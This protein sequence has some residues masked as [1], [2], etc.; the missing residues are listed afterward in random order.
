MGDW[1]PHVRRAV[2]ETPFVATAVSHDYFAVLGVPL[3]GGGFRATDD[4]P[5]ADA[6][7]IISLPL[8]RALF[9]GVD[10]LGRPIATTR[11]VLTVVGVVQS[12]FR[13]PRVGDHCD[14]WL[15]L[16]ALG[17]FADLARHPGVT[18]L[19]PVTAF[20]RLPSARALGVTQTLVRAV[21]GR[22]G[23]LVPL[24]EAYGHT[25]SPGALVRQRNLLSAMLLV[26]GMI[27]V[28]GAGNLVSLFLCRVED[29]HRSLAIRIALGASRL[30]VIRELL[31]G[32][33]LL[34]GAGLVVALCVASVLTRVIATTELPTGVRVGDALSGLHWFALLAGAAVAS[35]ACMAACLA[36]L[37]RTFAIDIARALA[38]PDR[39]P[40][41]R[42]VASHRAFLAFHSCVATT[43]LVIGLAAT[44]AI[45]S[46]FTDR[47]GFDT[48][49]TAFVAVQPRLAQYS[50]A[51][52]DLDA[53]HRA[54]DYARLLA[55]LRGVADVTSAVVGPTLIESTDSLAP[56]LQ[57]VADGHVHH[58]AAIFRAVGA[59]YLTTLGVPIIQGRDIT[60]MDRGRDVDVNALLRDPAMAARFQVSAQG[61]PPAPLVLAQRP[62]AVIDETLARV[63]WPG[64]SALGQRFSCGF[65]NIEY[66]VIG[67]SAP[68]GLPTDAASPV[69]TVVTLAPEGSLLSSPDVNVVLHTTHNASSSVGLLRRLTAATF[70]DPAHLQVYTGTDV[71]TVRTARRRLLAHLVA[72]F[73]VLAVALTAIGVVGLVDYVIEV[74]RRECLIRSMLGVPVGR[75]RLDIVR[76]SLAPIIVGIV[77][78]WPCAA[79]VGIV[80]HRLVGLVDSRATSYY[81]VGS[82]ITAGVTSLTA[83]AATASRVLD[84][85]L[86]GGSTG[87]IL[88]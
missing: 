80:L 23:S 4:S 28:I 79:S 59:G 42:T 58:V 71:M 82:L 31:P 40:S 36:V 86:A 38:S 27:A 44:I 56:D 9:G 12:A 77:A 67:V 62:V 8:S 43:L 24:A 69:A 68:L 73:A 14:V 81:I 15:P 21:I 6:I 53:A 85:G 76:Y 19:M 20:F 55:S 47:A 84:V 18:R 46:A 57:V 29:Q 50:T 41:R 5:P 52:S 65:L 45:H 83:L 64:R 37:R 3:R 70:P 74:R 87:A 26:A 33:L 7:A 60:A 63:L 48:A 2:D 72:M 32:L 10:A 39:D 22:H 34:A 61:L 16:G 88:K 25:Q 78:A 17:R 54:R 35:V 13:G 49:H 66:E 1:R 51:L 75:I 30:A 11:G